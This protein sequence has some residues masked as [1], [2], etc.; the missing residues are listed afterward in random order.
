MSRRTTI[1]DVAQ[2]AGVSIATVSFAF[3]QPHRVKQETLN[4]VLA[5][6]DELGYTP[7]ASARG[8][9][10]GRT[11]AI[12]LFSFDYLID[13]PAAADDA[14]RSFPLYVD[15]VQHG[16]ELECRRLGY[17]L[18][19]GGGR[20]SPTTPTIVDIVG[21]VDGLIA[22]AGTLPPD[23]LSGV[24]QRIPL[25]ALGTDVDGLHAGTVRVDDAGGTSAVV[26]HL[27]TVHDRRRL[28]FLGEPRT[29]EKADRQAAFERT[30]VAAGLPILA[31]PPSRPGLDDTTE[32]AVRA[33]LDWD[34]PPDAFV[35]STDEEAI[36][37]MDTLRAAGIAVPGQVAVTGFDGIV[38]GRLCRPTLTTVRQPM[39]RIGRTAVRALV[40]MLDADAEDGPDA[41][42]SPGAQLS[43][44]LVIGESCGC[45]ATAR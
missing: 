29:R 22:F 38:A 21:R 41:A 2:R 16:V 12:G 35:C 33:C 36:V 3:S 13:R 43:V 26:E 25:V 18:M 27:L 5:A 40:E 8:L 14:C 42:E 11:G 34:A 6:A 24:A 1:Y 15:E 10:K 37:V 28:V 20:T 19:V 30:V 32:R 39:E 7:S 45:P 9:A 23:V 31:A 17:A 44:E 4:T